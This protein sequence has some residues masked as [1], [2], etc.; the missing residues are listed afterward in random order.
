[1]RYND[2]LGKSRMSVNPMFSFTH[3]GRTKPTGFLATSVRGRD[4]GAEHV[5]DVRRVWGAGGMFDGPILGSPAARVPKEQTVEAAMGLMKQVFA[6]A[7]SRGVGVNFALD[8]DTHS[9]N[10]QNVVLTLPESARILTG[11]YW[12]ANPDT[13]EG[14][15]YWE[16]QVR[17]LLGAYPQI[18]RVVIWFREPGSPW[19]PWRDL[20]PADFPARWKAEYQQAI[21]KTPALKADRHAPGMFAIN[22]IVR[23]FHK[24]LDLRA[25]GGA[26][27]RRRRESHRRQVSAAL[28]Y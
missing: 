2:P 27:V 6:Y 21:E 25:D 14:F 3:N 8:V 20:P 22:K 10:P 15:A 1:M 18:S 11:N 9:A 28:D 23:A 17:Q 16:S 5:N 13:R 4:W 7:E 19:S 24:S 12:L 26:Y